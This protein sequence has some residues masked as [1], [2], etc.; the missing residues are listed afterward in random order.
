MMRRGMIKELCDRK[1]NI[2]Q[3]RPIEIAKHHTLFCLLFCGLHQ[4]HLRA[5]IFPALAVIDYSVDPFP[6]L[7]IHRLAKFALPP[8]IERQVRIQVR[9]NYAREQSRTTALEQE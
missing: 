1:T 3:S 7:W 8:K 9:E 6:K 4:A 2:V 5:K